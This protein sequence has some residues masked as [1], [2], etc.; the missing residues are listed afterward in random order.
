MGGLGGEMGAVVE[1]VA[2]GATGERC[3]H[4]FERL[5]LQSVSAKGWR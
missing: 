2:V 4:D 5:R 3:A 1:K